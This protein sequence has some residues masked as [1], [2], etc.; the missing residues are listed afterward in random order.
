MRFPAPSE[1]TPNAFNRGNVVERLIGTRVIRHGPRQPLRSKVISVICRSLA[2]PHSKRSR[3]RTGATRAAL[4][5]GW[6]G[7]RSRWTDSI[8]FYRFAR[9]TGV[10]NPHPEVR[11]RH[12]T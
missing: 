3:A 8:M 4:L 10:V 1:A 5:T 7:M 12:R 9:I 11:Y 6:P 2:H